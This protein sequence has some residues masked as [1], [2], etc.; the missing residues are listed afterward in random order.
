VSYIVKATVVEASGREVR[1]SL[2]ESD[3]ELLERSVRGDRDAFDLLFL[4]YHPKVTRHILRMTQEVHAAEDLA[5][6]TMYLVWLKGSTWEGRGS[7]KGWIFRIA[8]N[9]TLNY[10]RSKKRTPIQPLEQRY[11]SEAEEEESVLERQ[12]ESS[13]PGPEVVYERRE[14]GETLQRIINALP[15]EKR[16]V[17]HLV[18]ELGFSIDET[19]AKLGIPQGTVKSRL[20]YGRKALEERLK[21]YLRTEPEGI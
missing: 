11:E 10:L 6:E 5:Q 18:H 1:K 16:E 13:L 4:R 17:L 19:S 15:E 20:F 3:E 12:L 2:T 9:R 8:S 21:H 14:A 7:V